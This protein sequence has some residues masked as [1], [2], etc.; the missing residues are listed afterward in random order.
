MI[1]SPLQ[2]QPEVVITAP[3][4]GMENRTGLHLQNYIA[5]CRL[6]LDLVQ[7]YLQLP[8]S[9]VLAIFFPL[10]W[11]YP[12]STFSDKVLE[13]KEGV[14]DC[15]WQC[16]PAAQLIALQLCASCF[17]DVI[18][19]KE[20]DTNRMKCPCNWICGAFLK[21]T[22]SLWIS[23]AF[24]LIRPPQWHPFVQEIVS[25]FHWWTWSPPYESYLQE[26]LDRCHIHLLDNLI[27]PVCLQI[28]CILFISCL[29]N[30]IRRRKILLG[31][32]K[33]DIWI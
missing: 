32:Y 19:F 27:V 15:S 7:F 11:S 20:G 29:Y 10:C 6:C 12:F 16:F 9:L 4:R 13:D 31:W 3:R 21:G 22:F 33:A 14:I 1:L 8:L 17:P 28:K 23:F 24:I 26:L 18:V 30:C 2:K 25:L 5:V